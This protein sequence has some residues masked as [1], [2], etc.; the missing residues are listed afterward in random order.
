[1]GGTGFRDS[2][3]AESPAPY[4]QL[5]EEWKAQYDNEA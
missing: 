5:Y 4:R 1:M 2:G 3:N